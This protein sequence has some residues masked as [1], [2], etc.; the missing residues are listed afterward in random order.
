M[1]G[2]GAERSGSGMMARRGRAVRL[3]L[4]LLAAA[5]LLAAGC[6]GKKAPEGRGGAGRVMVSGAGAT[7]PYPLYSKWFSEYAK[8]NPGV[9]IDYQSIGS[10]G[11]IKQ[12]QAGTVD[13][14]ASDAPMT[15]AELRK[16]PDVIH[17]PTVLGAVVVAY[18]LQGVPD[19]RL[20]PAV[21][22]DI[23]LGKIKRWNDP[24][25]GA[26][27]PGVALPALDI[28]VAHRSDGSG[29][30]YVFTDYLSAVSAEWKSKVG[31]GKSVDW[32]V[33]V[34]GKGNEGVSGVIRNTPGA[35]GYVELIYAEQTRIPYALI[36]NRDGNFVK[37]T[38][39]SVSAA[40]AGAAARMPE[41]LRVSIVNAPGKDSYPI[42]AFTY[43]LLDKN[44]KDEA[45]GRALVKFIWWALHDGER[46]ARELLYAPLP[47]EVLAKV[48]ARLRTVSYQGKPLLEE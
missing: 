31:T 48:E 8:V 34:G 3:A 4:A 27:N 41:D 16:T 46:Y 30:T 25:I 19:L 21:L 15:D 7:F 32:P 6:A 45:K 17:I 22:A 43:L 37:P 28:T 9:R 36:Q 2:L 11:G 39:E 23:F 12:L 20:T 5:G 13:F 18:N 44:Q 24:A 10:G 38:L 29:T 14:G 47:P 42:S 26:A 33:G 1:F 40:A 35:I